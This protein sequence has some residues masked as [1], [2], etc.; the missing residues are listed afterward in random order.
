MK[1]RNGKCSQRNSL[2]IYIKTFAA[3]EIGGGDVWK[4]ID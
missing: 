3:I 2:L 1:L 4:K